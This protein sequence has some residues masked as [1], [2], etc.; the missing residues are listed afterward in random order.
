MDVLQSGITIRPAYLISKSVDQLFG[1]IYILRYIGI[2]CLITLAIY[3]AVYC[4]NIV[5]FVMGVK[6]SEAWG[7]IGAL[8]EGFL[9]AIRPARL[10]PHS[11][12]TLAT[13]HRLIVQELLW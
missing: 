7:N 3:Y 1:S 8:L 12:M 2:S 11:D 5:F 10:W 4:A 6:A 13:F 9:F